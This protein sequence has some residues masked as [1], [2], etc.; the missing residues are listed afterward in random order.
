MVDDDHV[1]EWDLS[2]GNMFDCYLERFRIKNKPE[3]W[4]LSLTLEKSRFSFSSVYKNVV[5]FKTSMHF[6]H[7]PLT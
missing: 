2:T 5:V 7:E 3:K 1:P 6:L 4:Y